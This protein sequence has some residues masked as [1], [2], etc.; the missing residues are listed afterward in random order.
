MKYGIQEHIKIR[1]SGWQK[2]NTLRLKKI[3]TNKIA[4]NLLSL[5]SAE[6]AKRLLGFFTLAYLGRILD[7]SGFGIIGFASAFISYFILIVNFGFSTYGTVEIAKDKSKILLFVNNILTIRILLSV[8]LSIL[9]AVYVI[10]IE[11]NTLTRYVMMI[12]GLNIFANAIA[13]NWVFQAV[14][15]MKYIAIRQV[16]GGIISLAGVIIFVQSKEDVVTAAIILSLSMLIGN[17]W[18]IPVYQKIYSKI[19]LEF[20]FRFWKDLLVK[21]FPLA[22][23]SIMIGIYYNLDIVMLGYMKTEED[24]GIYSAAVKIFLLGVLPLQL[25][26]SAYFPSLSRVGLQNSSEFRLI[27]RNY[28]KF[29]IGTGIVAGVIL[30]SFTER[31]IVLVFGLS[32]IASAA[33]LSV[34]AINIMI[35]SINIF[36]GN[37][38]MAWGK[39]KEY[40]F[41]ITMGAVSNIILNVV[42]IPKYSYAGAALATLFS[43]I[44]VMIGLFYLFRKF[45][46]N[47]QLLKN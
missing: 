19:K 37:P 17:I 6:A 33:P 5:T 42:L 15:K 38:M 30:L 43:E 20:D 7:K 34:L 14:E 9:L 8:L 35:V 16:L 24:V 11:Q 13:L 40:S 41:A 1:K 10:L 3:F 21:S 32:Y 46:A 22:Y 45:T 28:G 31:I 36:L 39:N 47:L 29:I 27:M 2:N 12:T 25:I 23:A 4:S 18:F 26:F 44:S